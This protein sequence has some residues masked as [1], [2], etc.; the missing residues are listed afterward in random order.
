[1]LFPDHAADH[2][3]PLKSS[4]GYCQ[5]TYL[6]YVSAVTRTGPSYRYRFVGH[7]SRKNGTELRVIDD[8]EPVVRVGARAR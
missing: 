7:H 1:M 3:G 2:A 6:F 4:W 5:R 8:C